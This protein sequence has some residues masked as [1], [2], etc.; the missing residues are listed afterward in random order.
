MCLLMRGIY[1][2]RK[3]NVISFCRKSK[4][5]NPEIGTLNDYQKLEKVKRLFENE[6]YKEVINLLKKP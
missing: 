6:K 5:K 4:E 2:D 1:C 3:S